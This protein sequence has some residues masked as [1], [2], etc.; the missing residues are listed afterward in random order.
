MGADSMGNKFVP[1]NF[2]FPLHETDI[3]KMIWSIKHQVD[4][5]KRSP[6]PL[7]SN[8]GINFVVP[9]LIGSSMRMKLVDMMRCLF[10]KV[11]I[12][13]SNVPGPTA[14]VTLCGQPLDDMMFY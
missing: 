1:G 11:T 12:C 9:K 6:A 10:G 2:T 13:L 7:I 8:A 5:I 14:E 3:V 4:L